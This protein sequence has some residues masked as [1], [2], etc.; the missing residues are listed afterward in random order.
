MQDIQF[1]ST[2]SSRSQVCNDV[3]YR[4]DIPSGTLEMFNKAFK[5]WEI[6]RGFVNPGFMKSLRGIAARKQKQLEN[7][8][9]ESAKP[10]RS[11]KSAK[12]SKKKLC[13]SAKKS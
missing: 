9:K 5:A 10:S 3:D 1:K 12:P 2:I 7:S 11:K 4:P 6:K 8:S 13:S